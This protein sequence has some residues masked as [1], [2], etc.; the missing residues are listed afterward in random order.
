MEQGIPTISIFDSITATS[1]IQDCGK[2][3]YDELPQLIGKHGWYEGC[4][5]LVSAMQLYGLITYSPATKRFCAT[6]LGKKIGK[7]PDFISCV[8]AFLTPQLFRTIW[9]EGRQEEDDVVSFLEATLNPTRSRQIANVYLDSATYLFSLSRKEGN[10]E[11]D[12]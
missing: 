9:E 12:D 7:A 2:I 8:Q 11:E 6:P 1:L 10:N 5:K 4:R 3:G